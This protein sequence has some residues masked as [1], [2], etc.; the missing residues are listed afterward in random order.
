MAE[1]AERAAAEET[2]EQAAA[3]AAAEQAA[4]QAANATLAAGATQE[5]VAEALAT[6]AAEAAATEAAEAAETQDASMPDATALAVSAELRSTL[7]APNPQEPSRVAHTGTC[8]GVGGDYHALFWGGMCD[9]CC[10][11]RR[12]PA[13]LRD[14]LP[15]QSPP[16]KR[17]RSQQQF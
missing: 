13:C 2:A 4:Q 15:L 1:L 10:V 6:I 16:L 9:C 3:I 8:C 14:E 11:P 17:A 12:C 7:G 5:Q